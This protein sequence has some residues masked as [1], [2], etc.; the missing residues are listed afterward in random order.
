MSPILNIN[1]LDQLKVQI[2]HFESIVVL[3]LNSTCEDNNPEFRLY[4]NITSQ[5]SDL[6]FFCT[7]NTTIP[8]FFKL[9]NNTTQ[10]FILKNYDERFSHLKDSFTFFNIIHFIKSYAYPLLNSF[11][12]DNFIKVNNNRI[13]YSLLFLND[14][15]LEKDLSKKLYDALLSIPASREIYNMFGNFSDQT[16]TTLSLDFDIEKNHPPVLIITKYKLINTEYKVERYKTD[17]RDLETSD[18]I[19]NFFLKF[20]NGKLS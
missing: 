13:S 11:S 5:F 6:P 12:N 17:K 14:T 4:N 15:N 3:F 10:L 7:Q 18:S 2:N 16:Q 20:H 19:R 9:V 1:E 8:E